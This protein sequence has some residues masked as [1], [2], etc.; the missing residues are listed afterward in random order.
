MLVIKTKIMNIVDEAK[1]FVIDYFGKNSQS[2][3]AFHSLEHTMGVVTQAEL[4]AKHEKLSE[5][6]LQALLVAA[7]FHDVGYLTTLENHEAESV[8]IARSFFEQHPVAASFAETVE[9]CIAC[10][11]RD[12]EP[13]SLPEKII[14]DADVAHVGR[15]DFITISKKL[16]KEYSLCHEKEPTSLEYWTETLRFLETLVFYTDYAQ[17]N[18]LPEKEKNKQEVIALISELEEKDGDGKKSK[19]KERTPEK[20]VESMFRLTASNQMRLSAMADKK[21]NILISINSILISASAA[22]VTKSQLPDKSLMLPLLILF[23][24][25]LLSLVFSILSCRPKL[26]SGSVSKEDLQQKKVNL[27]FFGNFFRI[28]YPDYEKSMREMMED[29]DYLYS[30]MIKDQYFLGL[31]LLRKYKLLRMAYNLFMFGFIV[32]ALVF[33]FILLFIH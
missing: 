12:K 8:A 6:E 23:G 1:L 9:R 16:K 28:P 19:K 20:G 7:W 32:S 26:T 33:V 29:Y 3:L 15:P 10:T 18:F 24:A 22:L 5:T 14:L 21:A 27:L 30:N 4:I 31:S 17:Q 13:A 2:R 11:S 25:N